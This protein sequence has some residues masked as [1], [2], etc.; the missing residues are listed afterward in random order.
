MK[1][2]LKRLIPGALLC[3]LLSSAALAQPKIGTIDLRKV[4][5]NYW[6]T[7]QANEMLQSQQADM[8][9]TDKEL[10]AKAE[11]AKN[12]YQKLIA[13][14][15]DQ[16][17]SAEEKEKRRNAAEDKFKELN[18]DKDAIAQ[19]ERIAIN[20]REAQV[21]RTH[22][23]I[24]AEIRTVVSAKAKAGGFTLVVDV[25]DPVNTS[26]VVLYSNGENDVTDAVLTQLNAGAPIDIPKPAG[27]TNGAADDKKK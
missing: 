1:M 14:S 13:D 2:I 16:A 4:F 20:T 21:R 27:K 10:I 11:K 23:N 17:I 12:D 9:K 7:K 25:S 8:E 15:N 3:S 24:L 5:D 22:D 19:F 26:P 18:D 6:K